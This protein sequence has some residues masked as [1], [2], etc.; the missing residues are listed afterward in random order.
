MRITWGDGTNVDVNFLAKGAAKSQVAVEH[1]KL[2]NAAAVAKMK[3]LWGKALD[4][5]KARLER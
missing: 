4:S 2:P 5:L 1:D 3:A